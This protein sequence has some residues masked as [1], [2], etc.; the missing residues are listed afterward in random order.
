M[1]FQIRDVGRMPEVIGCKNKG[2]DG[3]S[4]QVPTLQATM[5]NID[6]ILFRP[7][8]KDEWDGIEHQLKFEIQE[9]HKGISNSKIKTMLKE[10]VGNIKNHVQHGGLIQLPSIYFK[11]TEKPKSVD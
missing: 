2:C 5:E 9:K 3:K 11:K 10:V 4:K 1:K 7:K 6:G 8:T